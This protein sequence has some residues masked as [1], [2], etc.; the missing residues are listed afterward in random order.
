MVENP[1]NNNDPVLRKESDRENYKYISHYIHY[2][3]KV[4]GQ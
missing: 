2:R 1:F 3:S 4:W